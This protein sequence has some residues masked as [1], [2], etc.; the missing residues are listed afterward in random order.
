[1]SEDRYAKYG[2][3]TGIASVV[4]MVVGFLIV[5]PAPPGLD[6][7]AQEWTTYFS[8]HQ[9][10]VNT[11]VILV[12]LALLAFIWFLGTLVSA[13]RVASGS[14][15]LPT[16]AFGGGLLSVATLFIGLSA[17]AAAAHRPDTTTPEITQA[18]NDVFVLAAV[19]AVAGLAAFFGATAL[20]I[21]RFRLLPD[22]V[23]WLSAVAA[24]VQFFAFGV[25]FTDT[26]AFAGDGALGFML[27][28]GLALATTLALSIVLIQN[29]DKLNRELGLGDRV[30]GV[31]TG[32]A[33]G[34]ASGISGRR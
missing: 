14:P 28:V 31:V 17:I 24:V 34:A 2:A 5:T 25:L 19:P 3:A 9:D 6:A 13:L 1:M 4:L 10:A 11:G 26:G 12:T 7:P 8:E 21:L 30:R 23:G 29:V 22:W 32:A 20:V 16:I 27:P 18:L 33:T 15:R